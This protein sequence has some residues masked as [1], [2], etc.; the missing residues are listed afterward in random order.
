MH[1][2]KIILVSFL[3]VAF[4]GGCAS[5]NVPLPPGTLNAAEVTALFSGKTVEAR[6]DENGRLSQT[7]YNPDGGMHQ[8]RNG[9][10]RKGTWMVKKNGRICLDFEGASEKCRIIIQE[11]SVYRKYIVKSDGNHEPLITYTSF[12]NGDLVGH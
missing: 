2:K 5:V 3:L 6:L 12:R 7:Y 10:M 4:L 11:G 9:Q 8:M 1:I